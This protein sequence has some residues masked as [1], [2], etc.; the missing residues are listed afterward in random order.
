MIRPSAEITQHFGEKPVAVI[1][2]SP[3][4]F[5]T[6]LSQNAWLPVRRTLGMRPCFGGRLMLSRADT[7]FE[8]GVLTDTATRERLAEFLAS[9]V[10]FAER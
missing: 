8:N 7:L 10:E 3:G 9:F 4:G 2:A 1:G 5:G 6:I